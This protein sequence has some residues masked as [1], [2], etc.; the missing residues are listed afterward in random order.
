MTALRAFHPDDAPSLLALFRDTIR[1]VNS[2][3]YD[4]NQIRAWASDDI[5]P[6]VWAGR[7]SGRFVPVAETA[8]WLIG[9][10]EL[11][12]NGHIDRFYVSADHQRQGIGRDLLVALVAE[13]RRQ[14]ITKLFT[15]ASITAR[16]FFESQG[17]I[18]PA[19]QVVTCRGAEFV[20]FR[21]ERPLGERSVSVVQTESTKRQDQR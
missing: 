15:E 19:P 4:P 3:D 11:E 12:M 16:P 5:D 8:G 13:A 20:N 14:G 17:F 6:I 7:F 1:R 21:M 18:V 10:A 9:F 2:R